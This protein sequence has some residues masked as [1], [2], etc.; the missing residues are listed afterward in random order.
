MKMK[1]EYWI[2]LILVGVVIYLITPKKIGVLDSASKNS[3]ESFEDFSGEDDSYADMA[4]K[5]VFP[6]APSLNLNNLTK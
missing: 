3:G 6:T 5:N 1:K 4:V 2:P